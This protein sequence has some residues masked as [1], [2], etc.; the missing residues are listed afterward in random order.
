MTHRKLFLILA[1]ATACGALAL[2]VARARDVPEVATGFVANV[3]CSETFVSG[4]DPKRNLAETTDAMP[5]AGPI[6]WAMDTKVDRQRKDVTV[7]L[8]GFGRSHAVYREGVGCTLEHG[9]ALADGRLSPLK[10]QAALLPEIA[11]PGLVAPQSPQLAAALDRAFA[12]PAE[13]PFRHTRAVVVMKDDRIVAERYADGIGTDTPLLGFS[14]TKSV[15][16]ALIGILVREGRLTRDQPVPIA[17]WQNPD[18]PRHA[19]TVDELLRHTA[20]LALGSSLQASLASVLEPVN[21]MKFMESDMAAFAERAPLESAPG[22]V[23]NYHDGNYLILSHLIRN[24]AGGRAADVMRFAREELFGPLGMRNVVMQFD[25]V[26]T[27]E[28]SGAMMASA[29]DWAR[30]G[31]LY[32]DDGVAGGKRILPEGWVKYSASPTPHAWVGYGAGFWTN[33]GD[34]FGANYRV[35]HGWPRDAF[36]AKG[37]IGQ[38]V[39]VVPSQHLVI[40]RLGRSPNMPPEADGVFDLV[41]D[42]VTATSA[43]ARLAGGN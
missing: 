23:W 11:G 27:P 38:Y 39:I 9:E 30:F 1:A 42:V 19:I 43:N 22:R 36:F 25:A 26:G 24:A 37:T 5:G 34:S 6:T 33:L 21:R 16:S 13:A 2:S 4:L 28:G 7:T 41:R 12:E 32:L 15:I 31:Q 3:I 18:D 20:G 17:A 10:P 35:E 14:A 8:F 29:R 40:V